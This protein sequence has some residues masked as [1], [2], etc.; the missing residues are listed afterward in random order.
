MDVQCKMSGC[1]DGK[2]VV[3]HRACLESEYGK[4]GRQRDSNYKSM[5]RA[6]ERMELVGA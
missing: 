4:M 6:I 2:T 3:Y 1:L 5:Q